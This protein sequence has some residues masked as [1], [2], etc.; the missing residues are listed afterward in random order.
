MK[1][2]VEL[3]IRYI[4]QFWSLLNNLGLTSILLTYSEIIIFYFVKTKTFNL[5]IE[6]K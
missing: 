1:V 3:S 2:T 4:P 6:M 5:N